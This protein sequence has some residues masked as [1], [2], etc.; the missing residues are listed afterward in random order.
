MSTLSYLGPSF[1][2]IYIYIIIQ[3]Q[4]IYLFMND[5]VAII[6]GQVPILGKS[7]EFLY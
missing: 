3:F 4:V 5:Y 7:L 6:G 2:Y 1:I